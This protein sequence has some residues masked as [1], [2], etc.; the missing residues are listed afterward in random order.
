MNKPDQPR[1]RSPD[2][3]RRTHTAVTVTAAL[4]QLPHNSGTA[5]DV[6]I[7][8]HGPASG[9]IL[10]VLRAMEVQGQVRATRRVHRPVLWQLC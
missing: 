10:K 6:E 4:R 1:K 7:M 5:R 8:S 9:L 2:D 3:V